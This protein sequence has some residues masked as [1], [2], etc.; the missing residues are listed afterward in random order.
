MKVTARAVKAGG[1]PRSFAHRLRRH[2][3]QLEHRARQ[4]PR[5]AATGESRQ[6][7]EVLLEGHPGAV[8]PDRVRLAGLA[9]GQREDDRLR[10][11][12]DV[13]GKHQAVA[14]PGTASWPA[15]AIWSGRSVHGTEPGP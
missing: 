5:L 7:V 6:P 4:P 15:R 14:A 2:P 10:Q 13:E 1:L 11:V 3:R 12:V 8:V 9:A